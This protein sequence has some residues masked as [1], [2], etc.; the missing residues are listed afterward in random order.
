MSNNEMI[1]SPEW[2]SFSRIWKIVAIV[3]FILLV[4]LWLL[5][6]S[7]WSKNGGICGAQAEAT[8]AAESAAIADSDPPQLALNCD[9]VVRIPAGTPYV[10]DGATAFDSVDGSTQVDVSG[11][12]DH[13]TPGEYILSY[14]TTDA[15][16]NSSVATRTVVVEAIELPSSESDAEESTTQDSDTQESDTQKDSDTQTQTEAEQT[17]S[18]T[19]TG[20]TQS[21]N[22]GATQSTSTDGSVPATAKLYFDSGSAEYPADTNL[23][24]APVIAHLHRN[25][26]AMAV[27]SG[28]HSADGSPQYN[29]ELAKQRALSVRQLLQEAGLSA[30]RIILEKPIQTTGTGSAE[31]ARRVEVSVR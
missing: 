25:P 4:I 1:I 27:I 8:R 2:P 3:L 31:E 10:D 21:A 29:R 22:A 16:G 15:A 26:D 9:P 30:D 5:D 13:T 14:T 23:S 6:A 28:F 17:E 7:P 12:V 24:L 11:S 19:N 20:A 18:S